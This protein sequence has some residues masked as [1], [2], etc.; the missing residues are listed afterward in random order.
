MIKKSIQ[1]I[2]E[3]RVEFT[4]VSWP[5]REELVQ[6]TMVVIVVSLIVAAFIGAVDLGLNKLVGLVLG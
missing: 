3:V 2:K 1:F 6:S 5:S 4:K